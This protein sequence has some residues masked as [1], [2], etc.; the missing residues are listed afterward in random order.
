MTG[1]GIGSATWL[2]AE[3]NTI[4]RLFAQDVEDF[5]FS[6]RQEIDWLNEHMEGVFT[7][8]LGGV[9]VIPIL[10]KKLRGEGFPLMPV[11]P[12]FSRE[13][14]EL[15][16]TPRRKSAVGSAR[17]VGSAKKRLVG[18][19]KEKHKGKVARNL[20]VSFFSGGGWM[21]GVFFLLI[22]AAWE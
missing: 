14:A 7:A 4:N 12:P 5:A 13:I 1:A 10:K 9:Y 20:E 18:I 17:R 15:L 6:A 8:T 16:K 2:R 19:V 11:P 22:R 3:R 21:R